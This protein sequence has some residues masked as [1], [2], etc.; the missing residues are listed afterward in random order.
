MVK[1]TPARR[2]RSWV[3]HFRNTRPR[4][5]QAVRAEAEAAEHLQGLAAARVHRMNE[6][7]G[8]YRGTI[9]LELLAKLAWLLKV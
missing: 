4:A 3:D 8:R 2:A 9:T 5:V 7:V 1:A 6:L